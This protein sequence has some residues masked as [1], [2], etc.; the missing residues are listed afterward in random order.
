[1]T[2]PKETPQRLTSRRASELHAEVERTNGRID[3][4]ARRIDD[5]ERTHHALLRQLAT[6]CVTLIPRK[7][8]E[9]SEP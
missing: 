3:E 7:P 4:L 9:P 1:M 8:K 5:Q 6:A 2:A